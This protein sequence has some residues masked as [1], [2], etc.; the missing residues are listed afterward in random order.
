[1]NKAELSSNQDNSRNF[2]ADSMVG[3]YV[4]VRSM[5]EGV[6]AGFVERAD[7]TGVILL[8]ARR[9]WYHKPADPALSWYEGVAVSGVSKDSKLSCPVERKAIIEDYSMTECTDV[10]KKSIS[11]A[12]IYA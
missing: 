6:N 11:E 4:I 1:M 5:N 3:K 10:A 7:E 8:E 2:I 9:L 12:L